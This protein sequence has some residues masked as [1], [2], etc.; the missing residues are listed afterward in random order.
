[1]TLDELNKIVDDLRKDRDTWKAR[2]ETPFVRFDAWEME[3]NEPW[4]PPQYRIAGYR[5]D[6]QMVLLS[7]LYLRDELVRGATARAEKAEA[8]L[9]DLRDQLERLV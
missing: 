5:E 4:K 6:G 3:N 7:P 1:M 9:K 8:A 2:Y